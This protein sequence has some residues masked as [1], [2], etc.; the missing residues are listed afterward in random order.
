MSSL[1]PTQQDRARKFESLVL[2][3]LA[4]TGQ[5]P[6]ADA[7][8]VNESTISRMKEG[9][10][11][12]LCEMLAVIGLKIVP[13]DMQCYRAEDIEPYIQIAKQHLERMQSARELEWHN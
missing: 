3:H 1:N 9:G 11:A 6:V 4:S 13:A 12:N 2:Q 7:L 8:G 10:I 5:K